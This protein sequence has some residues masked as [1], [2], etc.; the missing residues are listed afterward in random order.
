MLLPTALH[1]RPTPRRLVISFDVIRSC[2]DP[3]Y[4]SWRLGLRVVIIRVG[5]MMNAT[6]WTT[7]TKL[8]GVI[9][10]QQRVMNAIMFRTIAN[11]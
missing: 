9:T 10:L 1:R 3:S 6:S 5:V 7:K 8:A 2:L 4:V 11:T